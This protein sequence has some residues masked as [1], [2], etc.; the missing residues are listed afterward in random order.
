MKR[1]R[2]T[3][4]PAL[5]LFG[6]IL[7]L[8][9]CVVSVGNSDGERESDWAETERDNRAEI[10]RLEPGTPIENVRSRLGTPAFSESLERNEGQYRVF[11]YRTQRIEADGMT[12]RDETTP[13]VFRDGVLVEWG[14]A[15]WRRLSGQP[16]D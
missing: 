14:E 13:L 4:T 16:L 8:S 1:N 10:S 7:L 5:G 15:A 11:F 12:S 2:R 9:G 6:A 3:T